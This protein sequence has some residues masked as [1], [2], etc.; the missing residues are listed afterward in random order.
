[1]NTSPNPFNHI[2]MPKVLYHRSDNSNSTIS[3]GITI[4]YESRE[5][6]LSWNTEGFIEF[7]DE[8]LI[9]HSFMPDETSQTANSQVVKKAKD[10]YNYLK[11]YCNRCNNENERDDRPLK[12]IL[13]EWFLHAFSTIFFKTQ[14]LYSKV[15]LHQGRGAV[16]GFDI[17]HYK[18]SENDLG[19]SLWLGEAKFYKTL[20]GAI[21]SA[22]KSL[23]KACEYEYLKAQERESGVNGEIAF[24]SRYSTAGKHGENQDTV[25]K[26]IDYLNMNQQISIDDFLQKISIPVLLVISEEEVKTISGMTKDEVKKAL[27]ESASKADDTF[28]KK[29]TKEY[30][31]LKNIDIRVIV[32]PLGNYE[33]LVKEFENMILGVVDK[34]G[35]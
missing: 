30:Q 15:Y 21:D 10:A 20:T 13:G 9:T 23:K 14:S 31:N 24:I 27:H 34:N 35:F 32:L 1:M 12:G 33:D 5:E 19:F 25:K 8:H 26:I 28:F 7:L 2:S 16:H 6:G 18:K 3:L 17:V 4:G 29:L 11:K 22:L